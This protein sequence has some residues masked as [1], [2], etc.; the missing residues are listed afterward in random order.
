M[1][2]VNAQDYIKKHQPMKWS[3]S[4]IADG[5]W[6]QDNTLTPLNNND[7][8]LGIYIDKVVE[9]LNAEIADRSN[10]TEVVNE[11][12]TEIGQIKD[13]IH[14]VNSSLADKK[15]RQ[16][17]LTFDGTAGKTVKK[18]TQNAN[19]ELNVEF[20][21]I[22]SSGVSQIE[23]ESSDNSIA[24]SNETAE[25]AAKY[26]LSV[27]T[28]IIATKESVDNVKTGLN[29]LTDTV[30]NH[31]TQIE[32]IQEN[33]NGIDSSLTDKKDKQTVLTFDGSAT[34]TV[35]KITQNANGELNVEFEDINLPQEVPNVE[36]KSKD[37][38]V[39]VAESTDSQT[40]TKTFDLSVDSITNITSSDGSINVS[41]ANG[42][43]VLTLPS[44]VVRD[45]AYTHIDAATANPLTDG[46]AA[47][48]VSVKYAR[49]DHVHPSDTTREMV[50]NK[51]TVVI[52]T[53]DSKYPTDKAVADFVNS[54]I[55]TNTANYISN[56]GGPFTSVAQL[57][58]Y[59][60]TVTNN[61]Y[62]FVT[63]TDS[64]GNTYY[65]R[66][67]A[68]VSG[69]TVTWSLEYRLNNSSFTAAQWAAINSGITATDVS[70]LANKMDKQTVGD[71]SSP[72]YLNNGVAQEAAGVNSHINDSSIH[73]PSVLPISRGGTGADDRTEAEYN[74]LG[75][76]SDS[77][78]TDE[79]TLDN[80]KIPLVN[81]SISITNGV[82]R[83]LSFSVIWNWIKHK[84]GISTSGSS[85]KYLNEQGEWTTIAS[86]DMSGK[87]DKVSGAT[88]GDVATLDT[89]GNLVDSGVNFNPSTNTM[90]VNISGKASSA[91]SASATTSGSI[92]AND[93]LNSYNAANRNY[94]CNA[95]N[96]ST[97]TNKPSGAAGAFELEVI[98]GTGSTCVQIYYSRDDINFNYIR[99]RTGINDAWTD[100]AK[101]VDSSD[102]NKSAG[103]LTHPCY[104]DGGIPKQCYGVSTW[105]LFMGM[106]NGTAW[107]SISGTVK[108]V[109]KHQYVVTDASV[110]D[111]RNTGGTEGNTGCM[112][113][114]VKGDGNACRT[115]TVQYMDKFGNVRSFEI[116][117]GNSSHFT[118][119]NEFVVFWAESLFPLNHSVNR[120]CTIVPVR[121][122]DL[123][124]W[125]GESV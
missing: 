70:N 122:P 22:A 29:N 26:D 33:I 62:A 120:H 49:E 73:L 123:G 121:L 94:I 84:L 47:V 68:T 95:D 106:L 72:I 37:G 93:D 64:E 45:S 100:W 43:A 125:D 56:S 83:F 74:L 82:F 53:S 69:S 85:T 1:N 55:A 114:R 61:D 46:T 30:N 71:A 66:Y 89:N 111:L 91:E 98:R 65:D 97:V 108:P 31:T 52:G 28:N 77:E 99:K 107:T 58:A 103:S 109:G 90:S 110:I 32:Q 10:L 20:I 24:I 119:V 101:L 8:Q 2:P 116:Y 112:H 76:I 81:S 59:S 44:D 118:R 13:T 15:D 23:L 51:S 88:E 42:N 14:N 18:I 40:N 105:S 17:E 54:S 34:K 96:A 92:Q 4:T 75:S 27:N 124:T 113:I 7:E 41:S 36:I 80:R 50:S 102:I 19:G 78:V 67:K 86:P 11:H 104:L 38:S 21:D 57:K 87:A 25:S 115:L 79:S 6:M 60:G 3:R 39:N 48:G 35:K 117:W 63:G 16:S 9:G 12:T 5:K